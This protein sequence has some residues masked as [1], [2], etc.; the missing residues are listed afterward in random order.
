M[1]GVKGIKRGLVSRGHARGTRTTLYKREG[2]KQSDR[3][4]RSLRCKKVTTEKRTEIRR[5]TTRGERYP[6]EKKN[7][8]GCKTLYRVEKKAT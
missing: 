2:R 8:T 3:G 5:K 1:H 6:K 7:R 4:T